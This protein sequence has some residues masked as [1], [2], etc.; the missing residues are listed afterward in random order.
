MNK[1]QTIKVVQTKPLARIILNRPEVRNAL[2]ETMIK[3]LTAA[4]RSLGENTAIR[5]I[6]IE[7]AG[8]TFCAGLDLEYIL[9][10]GQAEFTENI[11]LATE[12]S[13]MYRIIYENPKAVLA[14]VHGYVVAGGVGLVAVSDLAICEQ[15]ARFSLSEVKVGLIPALI[16]PYCVNKIGHSHYCALG[17]TGEWIDALQARQI[18][19][20]QEVVSTE[21]LEKKT[22]NK[23]NLLLKAAPGAITKFKAYCRNMNAQDSPKL[24]AAIQASD[25]GQ[26]GS[27]AF[28]EK[29]LPRWVDQINE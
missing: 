14:K 26:E 3:E 1:Y 25:E 13:Q 27:S 21:A 24:I 16:G 15:N 20:V 23:V 28:L 22:I 18:G 19:L 9:K 12:L 11:R 7:G 8:N 6:I 17:I 4:F 29:R 10:S 2:N 5:V